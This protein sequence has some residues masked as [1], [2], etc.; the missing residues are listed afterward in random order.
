MRQNDRENKQ[1]M[2]SIE[3]YLQKR[4]MIGE[5]KQNGKDAAGAELAQGTAMKLA[6]L[7]YI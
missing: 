5:E 2:I 7:M 6:E 1:G 4:K 3:E